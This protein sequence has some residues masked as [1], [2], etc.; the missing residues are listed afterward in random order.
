MVWVN[1]VGVSCRPS[2]KHDLSPGQL[3]NLEVCQRAS[4]QVA[5]GFALRTPAS[6]DEYRTVHHRYPCRRSPLRVLK[7][8]Y[9][10]WSGQ[11]WWRKVKVSYQWL[12]N[13]IHRWPVGHHSFPVGGRWLRRATVYEHPLVTGQNISF[14]S[15]RIRS[16]SLLQ[17][18][19]SAKA[20]D[21]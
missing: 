3:R 7:R 5:D 19:R 13:G 8:N 18:D 4:V 6:A 1:V 21:Q 17:M 20:H 15:I 16:I 10:K 11:G 12:E 14:S 9:W 2:G